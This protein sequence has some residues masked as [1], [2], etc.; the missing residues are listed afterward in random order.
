MKTISFYKVVYIDDAGNVIETDF[1]DESSARSFANS[2]A[3]CQIY[4]YKMLAQVTNIT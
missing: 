2:H 4:E 1:T 3:D